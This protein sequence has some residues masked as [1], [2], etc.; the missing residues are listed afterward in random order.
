MKSYIKHMSKQPRI[1][2][3]SPSWFG[4]FILGLLLLYILRWP[5]LF[6]VFLLFN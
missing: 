4:Y 2:E 6:I 1:K 3:Q 5:V